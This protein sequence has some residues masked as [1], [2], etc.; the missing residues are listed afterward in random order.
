MSEN[1]FVKRTRVG[2]R[3]WGTWCLCHPLLF[4]VLYSQVVPTSPRWASSSSS[5]P[6][7]SLPVLILRE[8]EREKKKATHRLRYASR[9]S[10][11]QKAASKDTNDR[12]S[13]RPQGSRE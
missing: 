4:W 7:G 3:S 13:S 1:I 5:A 6:L 8:R 12:P 11:S 2:E 9:N 10:K